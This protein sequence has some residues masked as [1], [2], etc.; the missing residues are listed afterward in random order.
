MKVQLAPAATVEPQVLLCVYSFAFPDKLILLI[1]T[2]VV[3]LFVSVAVCGALVVPIVCKP[4]GS[5]DG[6]I[7][8]V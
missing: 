3:P 1:V 7:V 5:E 2:V 8:T 6:E 4:K